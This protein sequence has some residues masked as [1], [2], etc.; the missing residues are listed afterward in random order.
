MQAQTN[1]MKLMESWRD[2]HVDAD[3]VFPSAWSDGRPKACVLAARCGHVLLGVSI[4]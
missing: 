1:W 3:V 2:Y 4:L